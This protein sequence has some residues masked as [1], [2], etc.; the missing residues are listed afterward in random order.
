[1]PAL[2]VEAYL[3]RVY[4]APPCWH[5]V[6]DVYHEALGEEPN[7]IQTISEAMRRA[8]RQFRLEL[9]KARDGMQQIDEPQDFA[10]VLMWATAGKRQ[11]HCGI[12]YAG[13][14]LHA[15][16]SGTLYQDMQTLRDAYPLMEFWVK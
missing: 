10:I 11:L 7:E 8:A 4:P 6:T 14:V 2:D 13:K 12:Y 9:F 16:E 15:L 1:M 3:A 5:L